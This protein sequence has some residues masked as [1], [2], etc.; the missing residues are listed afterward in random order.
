MKGAEVPQP[1]LEQLVYAFMLAENSQ[2]E[3]GTRFR[4]FIKEGGMKG[5]K[6]R[7]GTV[8]PVSRLE[9]VTARRRF[10]ILRRGSIV[11][12]RRVEAAEL[13]KK[14]D[15]LEGMIQRAEELNRRSELELTKELARLEELQ[16]G[17][18]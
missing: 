5:L 6:L 3:A 10:Q 8:D 7:I 11:S 13:R 9:S 1:V 16:E 2:R 12:W 18:Q 14:L 15:R 17:G 4:H